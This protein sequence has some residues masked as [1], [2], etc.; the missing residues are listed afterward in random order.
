LFFTL[1]REKQKKKNQ[2]Q[3]LDIQ[4]FVEDLTVATPE[5]GYFLA[6]FSLK[7][8]RRRSKEEKIEYQEGRGYY[9]PNTLMIRCLQRM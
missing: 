6:G 5:R 3:D 2:V 4:I 9:I 8:Y 1:K 7:K